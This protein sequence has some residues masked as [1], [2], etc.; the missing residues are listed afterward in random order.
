MATS[1]PITYLVMEDQ[2]PSVPRLASAW[3]RLREC[4]ARSTCM[5]EHP[6]GDRAGGGARERHV[7]PA[8]SAGLPWA[9]VG[10]DISRRPGTRARCLAARAWRRPASAAGAR[11]VSQ[12][13][14]ATGSGRDAIHGPAPGDGPAPRTRATGSGPDTGA[15]VT[16]AFTAMAGIGRAA[17]GIPGAAGMAWRDW[18]WPGC[19]DPCGQPLVPTD[20][21]DP[22]ESFRIRSPT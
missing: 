19:Q 15:G 21:R 4:Q 18:R 3:H 12:S 17:P 11:T 1:G 2:F 13:M 16:C 20:I 6:G 10:A 22:F 5:G 14:P 8:R 7:F 9:V